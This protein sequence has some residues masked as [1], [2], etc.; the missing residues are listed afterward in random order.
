MYILSNIKENIDRAWQ[1]ML[2]GRRLDLLNPSPLDI[3]AEDIAHGLSFLAR[4]NGQTF[5]EFPLSVAYHSL[6]VQELFSREIKNVA[7]QLVAL[8]HDAPEYVIGDM[9]SPV[10]NKIGPEYEKLEI[11]ILR[12]VHIK[13]GLPTTVPK[14]IKSKIKNADKSAAWIEA[15]QMAGFTEEEAD[16]IFGSQKDDFVKKYKFIPMSPFKTRE[17]FISRLNKL[18]EKIN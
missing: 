6:L 16:K 12:A 3:E 7:W 14:S 10:K 9:I 2:S 18:L 5:G 17:A 1:R 15:T 4:W 8:L 11:E 13:F